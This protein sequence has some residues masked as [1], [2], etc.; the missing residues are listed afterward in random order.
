MGASTYSALISIALAGVESGRNKF[1]NQVSI[2]DEI[3]FSKNWSYSGY[4]VV[5][6]L[7]ETIAFFYQALHGA[8]CLQTG[9]LDLA[10]KFVK[11]PMEFP[12]WNESIPVWRNKGVMGWPKSL[13]HHATVAWKTLV[14][15][16]DSWSW[17]NTVFG[18]SDE[19]Q[20]SIGAYYM[21]LNVHEYVHTLAS[22]NI[23]PL[24]EM[25]LDLEVPLCFNSLNDEIKRRAYRLLTNETS[26]VINIWRSAGVEDSD[27][28]KY[29]NVWMSIC[30]S[31]ENEVYRFRRRKQ[32]VHS[33]LIEEV[34]PNITS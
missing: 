31:W 12:G 21:A 17:L 32:L 19:Y 9:Q 18:D 2:L 34:L 7:P 25:Q 28:A 24:K 29:W 3:L 8:M 4:T 5:V 33:K 6:E 16:P 27:V 11:T 1:N 26:Q 15:L 30:N 14:S 10:I 13:T 20:I 22:N 23:E